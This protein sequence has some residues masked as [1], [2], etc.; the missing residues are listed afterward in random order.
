M[1]DLFKRDWYNSTVVCLRDS[2]SP[3]SR[4]RAVRELFGSLIFWNSYEIVVYMYV[5]FL[6]SCLVLLVIGDV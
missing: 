5:Q 3:M 4:T 1:F 2:F 6:L